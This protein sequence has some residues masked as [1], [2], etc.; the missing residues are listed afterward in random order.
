LGLQVSV[1]WSVVLGFEELSAVDG[2]LGVD[3]VAEAVD[4]DVVVVPA[5]GDE[6]VGVVVAAVG[7]LADVVGLEPVAAVASLD[8]ALVLVPPGHVAAD[9]AG[10]GFSHIGIGDGVEPVGDDQADLAGAEDL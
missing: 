6:V 8:G 9:V 7:T 4:G 3:L 10:Y 1:G 2:G 5:E